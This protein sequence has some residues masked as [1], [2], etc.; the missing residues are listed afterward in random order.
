MTIKPDVWNTKPPTKAEVQDYCAKARTYGDL[1]MKGQALLIEL[2]FE[3][4]EGLRAK[5][6]PEQAEEVKEVVK[7]PE[8]TRRK[9][10]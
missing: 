3:L 8:K 7:E 6:K 10:V 4:V 2:V 5:E 1:S 9:K